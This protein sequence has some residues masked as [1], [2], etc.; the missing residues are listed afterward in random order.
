MWMHTYREKTTKKT[1]IVGRYN[2][3]PI[4]ISFKSTRGHCFA[5]LTMS[6]DYFAVV[7]I[8]H[9]ILTPGLTENTL[10]HIHTQGSMVIP[11][12]SSFHISFYLCIN[13]SSPSA[14]Y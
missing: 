3:N 9:H 4:I 5:L 14:P 10:T 7:E 8:H 12:P 6:Q 13:P 2:I 11:L 1:T